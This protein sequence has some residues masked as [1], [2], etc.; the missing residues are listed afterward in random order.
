MG[1]LLHRLFNEEQVRLFDPT[2]LRFACTCSREM[3][4]ETIGM[5]GQQEAEE[6]IDAEGGIEVACEFCNEHYHFDRVD[7]AELFTDAVTPE[8]NPDTLH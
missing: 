1:T 4:A 7:V 6:I 8:N 5:L 2:E 3:V